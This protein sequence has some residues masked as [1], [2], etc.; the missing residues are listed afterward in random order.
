MLR[1]SLELG[2]TQQIYKHSIVLKKKAIMDPN[3]SCS[4]NTLPHLKTTDLTKSLLHFFY[5]TTKDYIHILMLIFIEI[6]V[7]TTE[8]VDMVVDQFFRIL[9]R[10]LFRASFSYE[11][12]YYF[13][14]NVI[15]S[16]DNYV[17][18]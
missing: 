1:A 18:L 11:T 17:I 2:M 4:R 5:S 3:T 12:L 6:W 7:I 16:K 13:Y 14:C 10:L 15:K 8:T 9:K